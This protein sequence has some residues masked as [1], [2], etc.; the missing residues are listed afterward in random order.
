MKSSKS[1][2]IINEMECKLSEQSCQNNKRRK[3]AFDPS[4]K[5]EIKQYAF[6]N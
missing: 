4:L 1:N 6:R 2:R 3:K 5:L